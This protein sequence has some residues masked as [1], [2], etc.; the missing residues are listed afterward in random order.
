[1]S[2]AF[3]QRVREAAAEPAKRERAAAEATARQVQED[4]AKQAARQALEARFDREMPG[5]LNL[6]V[7]AA[8]EEGG[9]FHLMPDKPRA[10]SGQHLI[11]YRLVPRGF[12]TPDAPF[13]IQPGQSGKVVAHIVQESGPPLLH[14]LPGRG[15]LLTS[16]LDDEKLSAK[17]EDAMGAY[18]DF[19]TG[20]SRTPGTFH[21]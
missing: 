18:I 3:R 8:K 10:I 14:T 11:G 19:M 5:F 1:M 12:E 21:D 6:I 9:N 2:D 4:A 16:S 7:K 20:K 15:V 17:L 13:V